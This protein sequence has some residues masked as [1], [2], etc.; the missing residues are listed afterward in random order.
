MRTD[1]KSVM[2]VIASTD[3]TQLRVTSS[4]KASAV[5]GGISLEKDKELVIVQHRRNTLILTS[6]DDLTGTVIWTNKLIAVYSGHE[7]G[8]IPVYFSSCSHLVEPMPPV[9][10]WGIAASP[11]H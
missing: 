6:S 8:N 4:Q 1:F 11:H 9:R 2:L 10:V 7:C 3:S 5:E